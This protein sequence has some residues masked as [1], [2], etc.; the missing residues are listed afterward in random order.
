MFKCH[1]R[2]LTHS[3]F[4]HLSFSP[5]HIQ[6]GRHHPVLTA[7]YAVMVHGGAYRAQTFR[8]PCL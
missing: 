1:V 3:L 4:A 6:D 8:Q 2:L 5:Q 7:E